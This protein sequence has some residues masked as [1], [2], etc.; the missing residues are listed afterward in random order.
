MQD[1]AS[2]VQFTINETTRNMGYYL[3]DDIYSDWATL[4]K[5]I[6]M[7]QKK[8]SYLQNVKEAVRKDVER[9][10]GVLK[11]HFAIIYGSSRN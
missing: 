1:R 8:K 7:P 9:A 11:S 5:T 3:V 2:L 10:F 6:P 4:V